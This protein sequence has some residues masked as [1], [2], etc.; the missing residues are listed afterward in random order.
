MT[1]VEVRSRRSRPSVGG[2]HFGGGNDDR[3]RFSNPDPAVLQI[4][5]AA[6]VRGRAV[7]DVLPAAIYT[8][9][10]EGRI[11]YYNAAAAEL[12]GHRPTLGESEWC[13]SWKLYWPDGTPLPHAECPMAMAL[14]EKRAIRGMEAIAE[15]PDGSR[16]PF[17]PFPTPLFDDDGNS[18]G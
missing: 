16:A 1:T 14:K 8:T 2:G 4:A 17:A 15:R 18:V 9:D 13:G 5:Q 6:G 12:W 7:L 11:T 3:S 10:A